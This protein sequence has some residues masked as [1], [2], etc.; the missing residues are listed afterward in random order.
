MMGPSGVFWA[1]PIAFSAMTVASAVVFRRGRW[2][3]KHV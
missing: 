3:L 2:K 1:V